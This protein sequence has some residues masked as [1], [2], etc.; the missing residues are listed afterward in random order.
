MKITKETP[1][2]QY[3]RQKEKLKVNPD[4]SGQKS[5]EIKLEEKR[6]RAYKPKEVKGKPAPNKKKG[7]KG[8]PVQM[9][10]F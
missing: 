10:L 1:Q 9:N 5:K 8:G 6:E 4:K 2:S 3:V 7:D